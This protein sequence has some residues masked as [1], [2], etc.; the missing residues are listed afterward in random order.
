MVD[1]I[2][3]EFKR[4]TRLDIMGN[5]RAMRRL[6]TACERAKR[7]LSS[8]AIVSVEVDALIDGQDCNISMTRAR[9]E[10]LC[11][12][13]FRQAMEPVDQVLRD[14]KISKSQVDEIVLVGGSTRIPK[15]QA[16]LSEYFNGKELCKNIN[17]DEAVAYGAAVQAAILHGHGDEKTNDLL[18]LDV[19]PLTLGIETAG[20]IMTSMIPRNTVVPTKK[21][22]TFSTYSDNQPA[23]TIQVFEGERKFTRDCNQ[24][25]KF[26]LTGIPPMPRGQPQIEVTYDLDV[27]G[28]LT[29]TACEKSTGKSH[30][31]TITNE[32]GRL[33]P[34]DI[35]RMVAEAER[36]KADDEKNAKR[37]ESKNVL[38]GLLYSS[39]N[40]L[41]DDKLKDKFSEE[42]KNTL[43]TKINEVQEWL[44]SNLEA[45]TEEFEAKHKELESVVH[46]VMKDVYG[47]EG[48]PGGMPGGMGG[49]P[50]MPE[51]M[52]MNKLQEM[53]AKMSPEERDNI[54]K[55]AAQQMGTGGM[56]GM[57][58]ME[59]FPGMNTTSSNNSEPVVEEVD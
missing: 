45:S 55:M 31:I 16:L 41:N 48:A 39:K 46:S 43:K 13:I 53:F 9:F 44:D 22:Q 49:M 54:Q 4:K 6:K 32:R 12:D 15:I 35:E 42:D 28:I 21:T 19:C 51:G 20:N 11:S 23:C 27:N 37:V 34:E 47:S 17:P 33:S 58:G 59:G 36:F 8:S 57:P 7:T 29:V 18:L 52:D 40:S 50:G 24:L 26:D 2:A 10:E 14:S 30:N 25:G 1:F 56:P 38:E 3:Q 5:A